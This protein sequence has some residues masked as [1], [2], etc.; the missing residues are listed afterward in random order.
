[1]Q[2]R[3]FYAP[4]QNI[5]GAIAKLSTDETRHLSRVL[6]LKSGDE[7]FVFDGCGR[8]YRCTFLKVDEDCAR[9][10]VLDELLDAVESPLR[11]TLGQSLAKGDKFDFIVQKATELGVSS[12][13]PLITDHADVKLADERGAKRLE[14]W[15]RI[16][17]E[18]LKQ[19]G[20]RTIVETRNPMSVTALLDIEAP[21]PAEQPLETRAVFV[22]S[23]KGGALVHTV[24]AGTPNTSAVTVLIGPE[25]G[26]SDDEFSLFAERGVKSVTLGPRTLRTETAAIVAMTLIQ[27]ALGDV[28]R[29]SKPRR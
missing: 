8:E 29:E 19:C 2:R 12:I 22:F 17:L 25:G 6:R 4:P 11:L 3:R 14:R 24:L 7:A 21:H 20:R 1:M 10:R 27:H 23:E 9:L 26:W 5:N 13:V 28:S 18:A 16:S 15:R